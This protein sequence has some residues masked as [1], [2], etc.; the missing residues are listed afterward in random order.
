MWGVAMKHRSNA[1]PPVSRASSITRSPTQQYANPFRVSVMLSR[2]TSNS[3]KNQE[4]CGNQHGIRQ[5]AE[6]LL[7]FKHFPPAFRRNETLF[8]LRR[9]LLLMDRVEVCRSMKL[10]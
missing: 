9:V 1:E 4:D 5:Q 3:D 7:R 10:L 6:A 8:S 2:P